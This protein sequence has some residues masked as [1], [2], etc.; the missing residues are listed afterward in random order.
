MSTRAHLRRVYFSLGSNIGR[1]GAYLRDGVRDVALSD[2]ARVSNVY[3]TEP[4][5]GVPQDDF[6]N[7]VLE[8]TTTANADELLRRLRDAEGR[9]MR[10]REVRWG[11][12]TLD[13]DLVT[14]DDED[15]HDPDLLVP[16][17]RFRERRFVLAPLRELRP[18]LVS[19]A[20]LDL[21][22]GRVRALGTLDSV[23]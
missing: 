11:P 2:A 23:T 4:V 5:G 10:R 19:D 20:D 8:I 16:H 9:A 17:P 14:W 13:V 18:D 1:R 15:S 6:W 3:E 21:A 7:I 12:R 22:E